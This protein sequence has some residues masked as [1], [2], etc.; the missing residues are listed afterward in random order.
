MKLTL[1]VMLAFSI[2]SSSVATA[3]AHGLVAIWEWRAA[4]RAKFEAYAESERRA[5]QMGEL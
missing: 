5:R 4:R 1:E 3:I 2:I